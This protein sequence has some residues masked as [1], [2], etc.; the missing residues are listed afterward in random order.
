MVTETASPL[1][2]PTATQADTEGHETA[3]SDV[4][5]ATTTGPP[6]VPS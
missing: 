3:K 6:G 5:P 1:S 4:V 2:V